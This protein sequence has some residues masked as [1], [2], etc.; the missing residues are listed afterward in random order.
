ML[1]IAGERIATP[2]C[3]LARNDTIFDEFRTNLTAMHHQVCHCEPAR[4]L[5]W[6]SASLHPQDA[7]AFV[8]RQLQ[9]RKLQFILHPI[10]PH[11]GSLD[12]GKKG[13]DMEYIFCYNV[14]IKCKG[15]V[16]SHEMS[17]LR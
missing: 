9:N 17:V 11:F 15:G 12:K 4:R 7:V 16:G 3:A 6:Q 1:R 8:G 14:T 10:L 13:L 5:V 2:V